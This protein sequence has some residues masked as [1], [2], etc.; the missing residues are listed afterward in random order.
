MDFP[1]WPAGERAAPFGQASFA[2]IDLLTIPD[3]CDD[4]GV[5]IMARHNV[6]KD[7]GFAVRKIKFSGAIFRIPGPLR[8]IEDDDVFRKMGR[9]RDVVS[10]EPRYALDL[11][12]GF[13]LRR[14]P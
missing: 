7:R 3:E 2:V 9:F 4:H 12:F 8:L 10:Q 6:E 13:V 11:A 5:I 1:F 14:P